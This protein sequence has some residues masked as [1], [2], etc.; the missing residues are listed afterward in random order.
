MQFLQSL[1]VSE[2]RFGMEDGLNVRT[3][4]WFLLLW[5]AMCQVLNSAQN[6]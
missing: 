1:F 4:T 5:E 2:N 3:F 6:M